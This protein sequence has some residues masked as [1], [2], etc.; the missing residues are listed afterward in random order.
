M[1]GPED[2][3]RRSALRAEAAAH[4]RLAFDRA[5]IGMT[6]ARLDPGHEGELLLVNE[7]FARLLGTTPADLIG[8]RGPEFSLP[9]DRV[10]D[11]QVM[12]DLAVRRHGTSRREKRLRRVDGTIV[13]VRTTIT[14][15]VTA[16]QPELLLAHVED[17]SD[18]RG[19]EEELARRALYDG[20]TGLPNRALLVDVI[21]L[22]EH[23]EDDGRGRFA[24]L[25]LDLDRFKDVND[26]LGHAAGD[27]VLREVAGR[28]GAV[29]AGDTDALAARLAGDEFVVVTRVADEPAA[30]ELAARLYDTVAR[31]IVV[32]ERA[33]VVR[34]SIGI[35]LADG[36]RTGAEGLLHRA[37]A[38]M[39]HAKHRV[40]QPW[41]VY[42]E[43]LDA[44]T[45]RRISVEEDLRA[46]LAF[47]RFRLLY[48]PVV[49]LADGRVVA[50][51]ALLRLE[52]PDRGLLSPAA[53]ID[54][55]EDSDLILPIGAWVVDEAT[56]QL[57]QWQRRRPDLQMAVN[58]SARQVRHL[59]LM[60]LVMGSAR[61]HGADPADLHLEI[62]ERVLLEAN[63]DVLAQ[64]RA[65][66]DLGCELAI[67][68]FGTGY[69]SLAY[70]TRFPVTALK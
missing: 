21:E 52:H 57:V 7:A 11:L 55:A 41:A 18:R 20:L 43:E 47:E 30:R 65:V 51:E 12:A 2:E 1:G 25:Y 6:V 53:F 68:D 67:D 23:Q 45:A 33:L 13:W 3:A 44:I 63:D 58:V 69:S 19:V 62:T 40:R 48:Q 4:V 29:T 36:R 70:L 54:T 49:D 27:E 37:D 26:T 32:A 5:P 42:D 60:D 28:L 15:I 9:E 16:G 61:R 46:A 22:A 56:R 64:L 39:Y 10:V 59:E 35:A 24:V 8:R 38:A 66:T 14:P 31:P 50:A 34:P 17:I